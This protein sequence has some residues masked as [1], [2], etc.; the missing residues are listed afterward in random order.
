MTVVERGLE[1]WPHVKQYVTSVKKKRWQTP[2]MSFSV[3]AA[4]CGGA[5]FEVNANIF[6]S[7]ANDVAHFLK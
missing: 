1:M 3:V 7:I 6:L 5:L 2:K 4:S